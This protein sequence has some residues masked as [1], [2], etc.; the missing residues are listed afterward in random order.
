MTNKFRHKRAT[1]LSP[2]ATPWADMTKAETTAL[3]GQLNSA[4]GNALRVDGADETNALKGQLN[5]T[6]G[7]ALGK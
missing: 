3:K 7:N 4:Q 2:T 1:K 5:S 6:Q